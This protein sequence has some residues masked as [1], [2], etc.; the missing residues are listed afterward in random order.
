M[1]LLAR[2]SETPTPVADAGEST[3]ELLAGAARASIDAEITVEAF[4]R[5]ATRRTWTRAPAC[6]STWR[7]ARSGPRSPSCASAARSPWPDGYYCGWP[8]ADALTDALTSNEIETRA[9]ICD[10][11]ATVA[12]I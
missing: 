3:R 1:L 5:A 7:T 4:M 12:A 8:P 6:R 11:A 10:A 9:W 2:M